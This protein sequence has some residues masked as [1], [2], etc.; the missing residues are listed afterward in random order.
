MDN[1]K[2]ELSKYFSDI[3]IN[4]GR[5]KEYLKNKEYSNALQE[6][7]IFELDSLTDNKET[8]M[9]A[10]NEVYQLYNNYSW[11]TCIMHD[12]PYNLHITLGVTK[13]K[14]AKQIVPL[15]IKYENLIIPIDLIKAG[16]FIIC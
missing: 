14:E 5:I 4:N 8:F 6:R 16:K 12:E 3:V 13:L 10:C 11:F 7:F 1:F 15:F 2:I 9:K